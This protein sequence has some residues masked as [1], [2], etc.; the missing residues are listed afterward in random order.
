MTTGAHYRQSGSLC[1]TRVMTANE[2]SPCRSLGSGDL[3]DTLPNREVEF[4][5]QIVL[6]G[7]LF[8]IDVDLECRAILE[9]MVS[10]IC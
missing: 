3:G 1:E 4:G 10:G 8:L 6:C 9:D 7:T 2:R 5:V